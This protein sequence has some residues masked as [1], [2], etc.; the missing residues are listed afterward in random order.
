MLHYNINYV[1]VV[2]ETGLVG[3]WQYD[4][5]FDFHVH[6]FAPGGYEIA[7]A[8]DLWHTRHMMLVYVKNRQPVLFHSHRRGNSPIWVRTKF[9]VAEVVLV[10]TVSPYLQ[11]IDTMQ[12]LLLLDEVDMLCQVVHKYVICN[13]S[14][15]YTTLFC[16]RVHTRKHKSHLNTC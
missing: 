4:D 9:I 13:F 10:V 6:P 1:R 12:L 2:R 8:D 16:L 11:Y 3:E 15:Q 14:D 5:F 7:Q